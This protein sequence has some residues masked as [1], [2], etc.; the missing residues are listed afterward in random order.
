MK[1]SIFLLE[2][3][4]IC[5]TYP[6]K[7]MCSFYLPPYPEID[8]LFFVIGIS[9]ILLIYFNRSGKLISCNFHNIKNAHTQL[10]GSYF[11]PLYTGDNKMHYSFLLHHFH[12]TACWWTFCFCFCVSRTTN[13]FNQILFHL[14]LFNVMCIVYDYT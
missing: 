9:L 11:V 3:N 7:V 4:Q 13:M 14:H 2:L 1:F 10:L 12:Q 6:S 5:T 8:I